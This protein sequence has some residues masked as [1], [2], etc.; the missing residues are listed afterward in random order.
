MTDITSR[1]C[2][3]H[4]YSDIAAQ[5]RRYEEQE[6]HL[7]KVIQ[8]IIETVRDEPANALMIAQLA[9]LDLIGDP[10]T[11]NAIQPVTDAIVN[12]AKTGEIL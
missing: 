7:R 3:Q 4:T 12:R 1:N 8:R 6:L 10:P 11:T 5:L 2:H 9:L